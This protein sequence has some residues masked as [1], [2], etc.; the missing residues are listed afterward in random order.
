MLPEVQAELIQH[1]VTV[2]LSLLSGGVGAAAVNWLATRR[3]TAA[4]TA[5]ED[6]QADKA[7]AEAESTRINAAIKLLDEYQEDRARLVIRVDD[8]E[9]DCKKL[10]STVNFLV[11]Q[12][13][14]L[15]RDKVRQNTVIEAYQETVDKIKAEL[16]DVKTELERYKRVVVRLFEW[17]RKQGLE[18]P[19]LE[20]LERE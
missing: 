4:E 9:G 13:N 14:E 2:V 10:K 19:T 5:H 8:L 15:Q 1:L 17:I 18:P 12:N 11:E 3:K 6:A 16:A 7:H 20:E